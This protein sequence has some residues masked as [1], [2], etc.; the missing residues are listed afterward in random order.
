MGIRT[1]RELLQSLRDDRRL[2]IDGERVEDVT[3]DPRFAGGR[4]AW[5]SSTTCSTIRGSLAG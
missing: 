5:P 4:R 2:F 3:T 1:G